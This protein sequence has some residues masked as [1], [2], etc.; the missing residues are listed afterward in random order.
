[1]QKYSTIRKN[2]KLTAIFAT[3]AIFILAACSDNNTKPIYEAYEPIASSFYGIW[4]EVGSTD[5]RG[6]KVVFTF[7]NVTATHYDDVYGNTVFYDNAKY[8]AVFNEVFS[9]IQLSDLPD[10]GWSF[11]GKHTTKFAFNNDTLFIERFIPNDAT[12]PYPANLN[13]IY[14]VREDNK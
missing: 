4:Y 12:I 9:E 11:E 5:A 13:C 2:L 6:I 3:I 7:T 8:Y 14:L 10:N 1:M